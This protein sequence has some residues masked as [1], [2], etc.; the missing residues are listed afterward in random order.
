MARL[1][2]LAVSSAARLAGLTRLHR[3][4]VARFDTLDGWRYPTYL[5]TAFAEIG[6]VSV[7]PGDAR[8]ARRILGWRRFLTRVDLDGRL[9]RA[10]LVDLGLRECAVRRSTR[11]RRI[12]VLRSYHGTPSANQM[13]APYF[14]H[15][16]FYVRGLFRRCRTARSTTRPMRIFF[17]GTSEATSYTEQF[18]FGMLRRPEILQFVIDHF[19][20]THLADT[21]PRGQIVLSIIDRPGQDISKHPLT[22]GD[23]LRTVGKADFFLCVPGFRVPHAHNLVEAMSVGTIPILNYGHVVHPPL[24]PGDNCLA[25]ETLHDLRDVVQHALTMNADEIARMRANVIA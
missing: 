17:A 13:Y 3:R 18:G 4:P 14:A 22:L 21:G 1:R 11:S 25:F 24:A 23:Y 10:P 8:R 20:V 16:D 19:R 2:L 7:R 5:L 12:T 15:P 6:P 9:V